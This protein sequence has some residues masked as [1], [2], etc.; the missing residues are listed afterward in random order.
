MSAQLMDG[1]QVAADVLDSVR[2]D[3]EHLMVQ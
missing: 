2:D 3:V 1:K